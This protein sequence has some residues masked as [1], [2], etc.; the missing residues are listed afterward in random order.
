MLSFQEAREALLLIS[1]S[2][3]V[4]VSILFQFDPKSPDKELFLRGAVESG[5]D[6][7]IFSASA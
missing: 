2:K 7:I 4:T 6:S 5:S 3:L 1:V